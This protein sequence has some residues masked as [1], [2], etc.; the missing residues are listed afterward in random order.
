MLNILCIKFYVLGPISNVLAQKFG[1][2]TVCNIG[3]LLA[4]L[5][6][7]LSAFATGLTHLYLSFG[8]LLGKKLN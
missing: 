1:H 4:S 8:I 3:G 2:R 7:L 6:I 5:A